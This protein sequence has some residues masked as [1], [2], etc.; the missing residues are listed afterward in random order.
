M[1]HLQSLVHGALLYKVASPELLLTTACNLIILCH[2]SAVASEPVDCR[3]DV[4]ADSLSNALHVPSDKMLETK[5]TQKTYMTLSEYALQ[6][7]SSLS[8]CGAASRGSCCSV[9]GCWVVDPRWVGASKVVCRHDGIVDMDV[10]L[11]DRMPCSMNS[12]IDTIPSALF[13]SSLLKTI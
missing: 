3:V 8:A 2:G 12:L 6:A 13:I 4:T 5:G 10:I 7:L 9:C 1:T 11:G